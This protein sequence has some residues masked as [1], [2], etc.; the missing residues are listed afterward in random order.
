MDEVINSISSESDRAEI[1][2]DRDNI[3]DQLLDPKSADNTSLNQL[4][5]NFDKISI[6]GAVKD[7][8][9][10]LTKEDALS[11]IQDTIGLKEPLNLKDPWEKQP[12]EFQKYF[13]QQ[14][15]K[16]SDGL[17]NLQ[18]KYNESGKSLQESPRTMK[19]LGD[20]FDKSV[21]KGTFLDKL[22]DKGLEYFLISIIA[23]NLIGGAA[24][25]I[26]QSQK[27]RSDKVAQSVFEN[28][29][30]IGCYQYHTKTG[31]IRS[32]GICGDPCASQSQQT[33]QNKRICKWDNVNNVCVQ[34]DSKSCCKSCQSDTDC[35][36]SN[37]T[38]TKDSDCLLGYCTNG[39]CPN[40]L[41]LID[42]TCNCPDLTSPI[43]SQMQNGDLGF[44]GPNG[45]CTAASFIC[46]AQN[47]DGT[48]GACKPC[49]NNSYCTD[50]TG[51]D[52]DPT[53]ICTDSDWLNVPI[54]ASIDDAIIIL[55]NMAVNIDKWQP[56][57]LPLTFK[58]IM[59]LSGV[60]ILMV[61][62]WY[63]YYLVKHARK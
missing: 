13:A 22:N 48:G 37:K 46:K 30:A 63:L 45:V 26:A 20:F 42:G 43:L 5:N 2:F 25:A 61:V 33:C 10:A 59:I 35:N 56:S 31:T 32:L 41:C 38:C 47:A 49:N 12:P 16:V 34:D 36:S 52:T 18:D 3:R 44:C 55:D 1:N 8:E 60:S 29:Q 9:K 40:S 15:E 19:A 39:K 4:K 27:Q 6:E 21:K 17:K 7:I 24:A 57:G 14:I 23:L 58:I 28:F 51:Q 11:K 53:C 62:L 54:C 50:P